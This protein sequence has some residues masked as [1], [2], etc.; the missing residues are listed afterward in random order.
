MS[1]RRFG[2]YVVETTNEQRVLFPDAKCTKGDLLDYYQGVGPTMVPYLRDRPLSMHRY[3]SGIE[4]SGF[5]QQK[6]ED[7]FPEWIETV[8]VAKEG[9][10]IT[11]AICNKTATLVYL[12]QLGTVTP[13][14]WLSRI[15]DLL[16][17]DQLVI[18]LD[19][20]DDG[21]FDAVRRAAL[22]V[23]ELMEERGL[24]PYV[25]TTGSKGLHVRAPIRREHE[26]DAVRSY[27]RSF[28]AVL[29]DRH[30]DRLTTEQRKNKRRGRIYL[31]VSRV[32]YAQTAV[33]PYAV[34]ARPGA[35]VAAPIGWKELEEG[36][37]DARSFDI[38]NVPVRLAEHGDPWAGM[39]RKARSITIPE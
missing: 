10:Q 25:M 27:L 11:H 7:Y 34:R 16:K 14:V 19:P 15:D 23:R 4:G 20:P 32:A 6:S 17:P 12:A 38:R 18:D 8:T 37:V 30:S 2:R 35:P 31:D 9:G 13:H 22:D 5:F 36:R 28:A 29:A 39:F 21:D 33:P 3:P 26:F 1:K 24:A